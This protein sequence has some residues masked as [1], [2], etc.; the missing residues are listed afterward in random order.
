MVFVLVCVK[1]ESFLLAE[2]LPFEGSTQNL[3]KMLATCFLLSPKMSLNTSDPNR[4]ELLA[5]L[6]SMISKPCCFSHFP[7]FVWM[8]QSSARRAGLMQ[9][10]FILHI[11]FIIIIIIRQFSLLLLLGFILYIWGSEG[12]KQK[13]K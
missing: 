11:F 9:P 10:G 6:K 4:T 2:H 8:S 5:T 1:L 13:G 12:Q 3:L 7:R